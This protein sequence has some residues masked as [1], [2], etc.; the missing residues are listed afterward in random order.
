VDAAHVQ[1][2]T[3]EVF[4]SRQFQ[5]RG[6]WYYDVY[7]ELPDG[8]REAVGRVCD[9]VYYVKALARTEDEGTTTLHLVAVAPDGSRSTPARAQVRW[10]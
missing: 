8:R 1:D 4:L 5:D 9:E 6:V 7:R 3:A 2:G 10:A